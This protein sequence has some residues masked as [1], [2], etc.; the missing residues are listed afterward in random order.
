MRAAFLV[1]FTLVM[2]GVVSAAVPERELYGEYQAV[3]ESEWSL[4]LVL[5]E[6]HSFSLELSTWEPG[7]HD[8]GEI[9]KYVGKW[10]FHDSLVTLTYQGLTE[11]LRFDP[12]LSLEELG[13]EGGAPGLE[14]HTQKNGAVI[15]NTK[16]WK[17]SAIRKLYQ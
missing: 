6:D 16:L 4:E 9:K 1:L 17:R 14:G 8:K 12:N 15:G 11:E 5:R 7:E 3:S 2:P 10:S 13:F